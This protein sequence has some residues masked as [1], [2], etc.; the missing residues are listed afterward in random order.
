MDLSSSNQVDANGQSDYNCNKQNFEGENLAPPAANTSCENGKNR[1]SSPNCQSSV[2]S[3]MQESG[4]FQW[5]L[6]YGCDR[7]FMKG[8][9]SHPTS[10]FSFDEN[11][12]SYDDLSKNI[13][14][15]LAEIDMETF[16]SEDINS[17]LSLPAL[18]GESFTSIA[19]DLPNTL[20]SYSSGG[21]VETNSHSTSEESSEISIYKTEPLFSPVKEPET[22]L[23]AMS[24]DS[25]DYSTLGKHD[26]SLTCQALKNNYTIAFEGSGTQLS[27]GSSGSA[28]VCNLEMFG[29]GSMIQ[30]DIGFTTWSKVQNVMKKK[31]NP[32]KPCAPNTKSFSMPSLSAEEMAYSVNE[33]F[34]SRDSVLIYDVHSSQSMSSQDSSTDSPR[35]PSLL[36]L[37]M[38]HKNAGSLTSS[39]SVS[40]SSTSSPRKNNLK[41]P[42]PSDKSV[43]NKNV[44]QA[45][46]S[47]LDPNNTKSHD[48]IDFP[49]NMRPTVTE[50]NCNS[51][52]LIM[53]TSLDNA[54]NNN[55][56]CIVSQNNNTRV[57][58]PINDNE[59]ENSLY[60]ED[61]LI[62][63]TPPKTKLAYASPIKEEEEPFEF[64]SGEETMRESKDVFLSG[65]EKSENE[66][67][68]KKKPFSLQTAQL[69]DSK[70]VKANSFSPG[71]K[72]VNFKALSNLKQKTSDLISENHSQSTQTKFAFQRNQEDLFHSPLYVTKTAHLKCDAASQ[73]RPEGRGSPVP[74]FDCNIVKKDLPL[75]FNKPEPPAV[76]KKCNVMIMKTC[77]T[78]TQ[79]PVHIKDKAIQTSLTDD[80]IFTPVKPEPSDQ[81]SPSHSVRCATHRD[82]P[83]KPFYIYYPNYSLPDLSF[84][85]SYQ[86]IGETVD[87]PHLHRK[88]SCGEK[89]LIKRRA[90]S[91]EGRCYRPTSYNCENLCPVNPIKDWAS[92]SILLPEK[93]K[94]IIRPLK[95]QEILIDT[96][97]DS[98]KEG[99]LRCTD[100]PPPLPKRS[101]SLCQKFEDIQLPPRSIL[102]KSVNCTVRQSHSAEYRNVVQHNPKRWSLQEPPFKCNF[103]GAGHN[104][105]LNSPDDPTKQRLSQEMHVSKSSKVP[106]DHAL[107]AQP[108]VCGR[109]SPL[110]HHVSDDHAPCLQMQSSPCTSCHQSNCVNITNDE[111]CRNHYH[112]HSDSYDYGV[113]MSK[114]TD[115]SKATDS[116]TNFESDLH[117]ECP[118]QEFVVSPSHCSPSPSSETTDMPVTEIEK[119][120]WMRLVNTKSGYL[121]GLEKAVNDIMASLHHKKYQLQ[122]SMSEE[123]SVA[124]FCQILYRIFSDGLQS[125][126]P[127]LPGSVSES[128]W[129][130]I[131]ASVLQDCHAKSLQRLVEDVTEQPFVEDTLRFH[132]FILALL[133]MGWLDMWMAHFIRNVKT[134]RLYYRPTSLLY[135][136][137]FPLATNLQNQ[138]LD[139]VRPLKD[140]SFNLEVG[141]VFQLNPYLSDENE[142]SK[143]EEEE[144][145][146]QTM[147]HHNVSKAWDKAPNDTVIW[148]G[149]TVY[150]FCQGHKEE[151]D[152]MPYA[153]HVKETHE[154]VV[155][156]HSAPNRKTKTLKDTSSNERNSNNVS[157]DSGC[158]SGI[159]PSNKE[160]FPRFQQLRQRWEKLT[161][162][163]DTT[164]ASK[165]TRTLPSKPEVPDTDH[166]RRPKPVVILRSPAKTANK[167]LSE[168]PVATPQT[169]RRRSLIPIHKGAKGI[170]NRRSGSAPSER[171]Q[172]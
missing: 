48:S 150:P 74:S 106:V 75:L 86:N 45:F 109:A 141:S 146:E 12:A 38:Q 21:K 126:V 154:T 56:I 30:S 39:D 8:F 130:V 28:K 47:N 158:S 33:K 127:E 83:N 58:K 123:N 98:H 37:Y 97:N 64:S 111:K 103:S 60:F 139:T 135:L 69:I 49:E 147:L 99:C 115:Q 93:V 63:A 134:I 136:L 118:P 105:C 9:D 35:S 144:I 121:E 140:V 23:G 22:K 148:S 149:T 46:I 31:M 85:R 170:A 79:V 117:C 67:L 44:Q 92:L 53:K 52:Q 82:S 94:G 112:L 16:R 51:A 155:H 70:N 133:N 101:L 124:T 169:E 10:I 43:K 61:S 113:N 156:N 78:S 145:K 76:P 84:L 128:V 164:A 17:I 72:L 80:G 167:N 62:E 122:E 73:V 110:C 160:E 153:T 102:R 34:R 168:N 81:P 96:Q 50:K 4:E 26:I 138:V 54:E 142:S 24:T 42:Y 114:K 65:S 3:F 14:A 25:L 36:K 166:Q 131:Q 129:Y 95:E 27:D 40:E 91:S 120:I 57:T 108:N 2:S 163:E 55:N 6:D 172:R 151:L 161:C 18:Y 132:G 15:N 104:S 89:T 68:K 125:S 100:N 137:T 71:D 7:D 171:G 119:T 19:E 107:V 87:H 157:V 88:V 116:K 152:K 59:E 20:D 143:E 90:R 5:C 66:I 41:V 11:Q 159:H 29:R 32:I 162:V 77:H 165:P 13:D 1:T